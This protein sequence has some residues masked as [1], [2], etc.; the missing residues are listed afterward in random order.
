MKYFHSPIITILS[1]VY[2]Y[3][4][5]FKLFCIV[6][7]N[8]MINCSYSLCFTLSVYLSISLTFSV[9]LSPCH[10][11]TISFIPSLS[12]SLCLCLFLCLDFCLFAHDFPSLLPLS[13]Y[14]LQ[15][16][17]GSSLVVLDLRNNYGGVIQDAMLDASLFLGDEKRRNTQI[18]SR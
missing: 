14:I 12:H 9:C 13:P 7:S 1:F 11:L 18:F 2:K 15:M 3:F 10:S 8:F 6:A 16:A 4:L 5:L 17:K